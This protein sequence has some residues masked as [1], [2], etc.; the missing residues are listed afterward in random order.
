VHSCI[1]DRPS[2]DSIENTK[3]VNESPAGHYKQQ[4]RSIQLQEQGRAKSAEQRPEYSDQRSHLRL[5]LIEK[6]VRCIVYLLFQDILGHA[7]KPVF[8]I[9]LLHDQLVAAVK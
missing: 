4:L 6:F 8:R 2:H 7:V 3:T 5:F 1:R 9:P